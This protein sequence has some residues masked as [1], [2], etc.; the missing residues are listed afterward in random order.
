[1]GNHCCQ[2]NGSGN[3]EIVDAG[4]SVVNPPE[5][6]ATQPEPE[7]AADPEPDAE[8]EKEPKLVI[9]V[10][11]ARGIR[12]SDWTPFKNSEASKP[13]C[14]CEV[15]LGGKTIHTTSTIDDC[16]EPVWAE[17]CSVAELGENQALEFAILDK[18][19]VGSESV[20]MASIQAKDFEA[21]GFNGEL[22][23][24]DAKV[25]QAYIRVKIKVAGKDLP[26]GPEP[27][28]AVTLTREK[29]KS[30]GV[31]FNMRDE[32]TLQLVEITDG[33][34]ATYNSI[35]PAHK[36]IRVHDFITRVNKVSGNSKAM[37]DELVAN[38]EV[39]IEVTRCV[40]TAIVYDRGE[41]HSPLG[42]EFAEAKTSDFAIVKSVSEAGHNA[43]AKDHGKICTGDRIISVGGQK[44]KATDLVKNLENSSGKVQIVLARPATCAVRSEHW[45]YKN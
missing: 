26:A 8:P 12:E 29:D 35:W 14:Y 15:R 2:E 31:K 21:K 45:Q 7:A 6:A 10:V 42:M 28:F 11:G 22:K 13:D 20:G 19:L 39:E 16:C 30:Y 24:A 1:M 41:P 34:F 23:L 32:R 3:A 5:D 18:D 4:A 43:N 37:K 27:K 17:E 9:T 36:H 44:G 33:P 25:D 40:Y 38:L